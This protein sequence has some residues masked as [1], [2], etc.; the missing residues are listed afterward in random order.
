VVR[1]DLTLDVS[2]LTDCEPQRVEQ[3]ELVDEESFRVFKATVRLFPLIRRE[4]SGAR[5]S[6]REI[7]FVIRVSRGRKTLTTK[8]SNFFFLSSLSRSIKDRSHRKARFPFNLKPRMRASYH[9]ISGNIVA[10]PCEPRRVFAISNP[11]RYRTNNNINSSTIALREMIR[12]KRQQRQRHKKPEKR[13]LKRI[14]LR[15]STI[16]FFSLTR[17]SSLLGK[18][19]TAL[20]HERSWGIFLSFVQSKKKDFFWLESGNEIFSSSS[21]FFPSTRLSG[22]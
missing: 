3:R 8:N 18:E 14:S 6:F 4:S 1:V 16:H 11:A 15:L 2:T 10:P 12:K 5:G 20:L 13:K 22:E 21:P 17:F 7:V 9:R 19:I